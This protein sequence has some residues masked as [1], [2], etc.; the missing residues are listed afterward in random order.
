MYR[1][2]GASLLA[3]VLIGGCATGPSSSP[4]ATSTPSPSA[5]SLQPSPSPTP[6]LTP[7]PTPVPVAGWTGLDWSD[8]VPGPRTDTGWVDMS[9]IVP[10]GDGYV[11]VGEL[12]TGYVEAGP[13]QTF[14]PG[15]TAAAFLT[16]P[17]GLHWTISQLGV[18]SS[19][20]DRCQSQ[21]EGGLFHV[22]A[23]GDELVAFGEGGCEGQ[24]PLLW[25]SVDGRAWK[26][27]DSPT[28]RAAWPT[29]TLGRNGYYAVAG[30]P[31]GI[32]AIGGISCNWGNPESPP[33]TVYSADGLTWDRL[34]P[35]TEFDH[36]YLRDVVAYAGGFVI[37]GRAGEADNPA[38]A[39][40]NDLDVSNGT[41]IAGVTR[42]AAWTS[43]D[44]RTWQK[45]SVPGDA[46][47]GARLNRVVA[48]AD[49][50][51]AVGKRAG[52][53]ELDSRPV[54]N[55]AGPG[56]SAWASADGLT[57]RFVGDFGVDLP[58]IE[59]L[60][61]DGSHMV[62]FGRDSCKATGHT[63]WSSTDGVTW[64]RLAFSGITNIPTNVAFICRDD[65]TLDGLPFDLGMSEIAVGRGGVVVEGTRSDESNDVLFW[66]ARATRP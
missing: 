32:V 15:S 64:T 61:G 58:Y 51:F 49:G 16:S 48:G 55:P 31:E 33:E 52:A 60:A 35:S 27:L 47:S 62:W 46:G 29:S 66:F 23:T 63:A 1:S 50:L 56:T 30:S 10:W 8:G 13:G 18:P 44:G 20:A 45:A 14:Q 38:G 11:G 2:L 6:T 25:R 36:A 26:R 28:W 21:Y 40:C 42:P 43:P 4:P 7:L 59:R 34:D 65:G 17:D 9:D 57:W 37:V 41:P 53:P 5:S 39:Q 19:Q 3:V 12:Y 54:L 24:A 22:V